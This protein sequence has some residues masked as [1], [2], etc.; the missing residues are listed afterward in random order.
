MAGKLPVLGVL[1]RESDGHLLINEANCGYTAPS[2][3]PD[4]IDDAILKMHQNRKSLR[5]LGRNGRSYAKKNFSKQTTV[6]QLLNLIA[7]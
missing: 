5:D 7:R 6:D 4:A 3:D 1:N 2:D